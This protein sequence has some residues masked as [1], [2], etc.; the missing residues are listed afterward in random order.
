MKKNNF[1]LEIVNK[2]P[3]TKPDKKTYDSLLKKSL[4]VLSGQKNLASKMKGGLIQLVFTADKEITLINAEYRGKNKPTDVVSLSYF[5]TDGFPGKDNLIGEIFI[6]VETA[7]KQAAENGHS[8]K[9]ESA[10]LFVHGILHIFGY[11]HMTRAE[12]RVMFALQ[13]AILKRL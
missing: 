1:S 10:F 8:L 5:E 2:V 4:D 12:E 11:D 6:S 3:G 7:K 13:D 9:I